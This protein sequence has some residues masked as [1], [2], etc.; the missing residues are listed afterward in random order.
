MVRCRRRS[1][2]PDQPLPPFIPTPVAVTKPLS[3]FR[4]IGL[5]LMAAIQAPYD[6]AE[7]GGSRAAQCCRRPSLRFH[8]RRL[9]VTTKCRKSLHRFRGLASLTI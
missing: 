6:E 7:I 1:M 9:F 8:P 3:L 2:R 4:G 5:D